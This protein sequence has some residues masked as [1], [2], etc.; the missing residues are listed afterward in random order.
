[1]TDAPRKTTAQILGAFRKELLQ[2]DMPVELADEL[3]DVAARMI[4]NGPGGLCV[5]HD[6]ADTAR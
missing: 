5:S 3:V 1:M 4:I 2:E 6:E